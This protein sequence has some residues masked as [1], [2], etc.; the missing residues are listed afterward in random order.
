[1][2]E[3][4]ESL[5]RAN[6]MKEIEPLALGFAIGEVEFGAA[7][8]G[9]AVAKGFG[10]RRPFRRVAFAAR[11]V[12]GVRVSVVPIGDHASP[13]RAFADASDSIGARRGVKLKTFK[14]EITRRRR[15]GFS[16]RPEREDA[17]MRI[18]CLVGLDHALPAELRGAR[19]G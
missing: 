8:R 12:G 17:P 18:A 1:M 4:R 19:N 14:L 10:E 13:A 9:N 5:G 16:G 6:R 15:Y 7:R 2:R 3:N 11:N